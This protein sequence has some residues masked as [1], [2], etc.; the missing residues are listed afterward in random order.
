MTNH[1]DEEQTKPTGVWADG[2][3]P[4]LNPSQD[5][6]AI[7]RQLYISDKDGTRIIDLNDMDQGEEPVDGLG[8]F[9][10]V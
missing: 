4:V 1:P 9:G 3:K 5:M 2:L 7:S 10:R 6:S 8:R